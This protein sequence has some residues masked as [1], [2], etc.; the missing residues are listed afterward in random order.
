[1]PF[2]PIEGGH[3]AT[4]QFGSPADAATVLIMGDDSPRP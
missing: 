3:L 4:Q 2:A 1:M